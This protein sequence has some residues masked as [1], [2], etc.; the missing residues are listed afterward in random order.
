MYLSSPDPAYEGLSLH[1]RF[2]RVSYFAWHVLLALALLLMIATAWLIAPHLFEHATLL[3]DASSIIAL[4]LLLIAQIGAVYFHII[5]TLRR[6]HD[7]A[8][9]PYWAVL[10][11]I[12]FANWLLASYLLFKPGVKTPNAFG[13]IR[14]TLNWEKYL[15][16]LT[17]VAIVVL[18]IYFI[19]FAN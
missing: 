13:D 3:F 9:N 19:L 7:C 17:V 12:P 11:I 2:G 4:L 15:S 1:G 5:F 6:L 10:C 8:L 14:H 16:S 18:S